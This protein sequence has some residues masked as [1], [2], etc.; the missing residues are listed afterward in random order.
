VRC[1]DLHSICRVAYPGENPSRGAARLDRRSGSPRAPESRQ[2]QIRPHR[3]VTENDDLDHRYELR[4]LDALPW[5]HGLGKFEYR[6]LERRLEAMLG[7]G[8]LES[9]VHQRAFQTNA[10]TALWSSRSCRRRNGAKTL[11]MLL[12][13][14][15]W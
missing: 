12:K 3:S 7:V 8:Y 15:L 6:R 10:I 13:R 4:T 2:R 5:P 14:P 9:T 1:D 11:S